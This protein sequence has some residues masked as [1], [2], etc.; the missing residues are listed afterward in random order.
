MLRSAYFPPAGGG[1][2]WAGG[3]EGAGWAARQAH[4]SQ[5]PQANGDQSRFPGI[6]HAL[7]AASAVGPFERGVAKKTRRHLQ[8][9]RA[10]ELAMRGQE[11]IQSRVSNHWT[12]LGAREHG[13]ARAGCQ[14]RPAR[15]LPA[16]L[17]TTVQP[18]AATAASD[19]KPAT[20]FQRKLESLAASCRAR[21][22]LPA[23]AAAPTA[24]NLCSCWSRNCNRLRNAVG[25]VPAANSPERST[26]PI[27]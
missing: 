6:C 4:D 11:L 14:L 1:A 27:R 2:C 10:A 5:R 15:A 23:P 20:S 17:P 12:A 22:L 24:A 8:C 9:R 25:M 7:C 13:V 18:M 3:P 19:A 26:S 21:G 16:K